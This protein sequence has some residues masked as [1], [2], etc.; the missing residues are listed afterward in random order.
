MPNE[1]TKR[2]L[3]AILSADAAGYTRLMS[4]DEVATVDRI[5]A[6]R[7][8]M[9]VRVNE[10][11]GRV[12][13]HPG[14][15]LLAEF[16]S[17]L[18]ATRCA[19][20]IQR[21][22]RNRNDDLPGTQRMPF[23]I[24]LHLG[25]VMIDHGDLYGEGINI[26]SRLEGLAEPG[27]ICISD[28]VHQVVRNKLD[29]DFEDL[30]EH[31]VKNM[32]DPV[33]VFGI[34]LGSRPSV[35]VKNEDGSSPSS[36]KPTIAVLSFDN[37]SSDPEQEYLCEGI[38]EDILNGL[39]KN[40]GLGVIA[41]TSS[42][43]FKGKN[44]DIRSIGKQ[45]NATHVLE[46]SIRKAGDRIRVTA[47]L[48]TTDTGTHLWSEQYDRKL[49]DHFEIQDDI[50]GEIL[51]ELQ[52]RLPTPEDEP[53]RTSDMEAYRAHLLGRYR[54]DRGQLIPAAAS[55]EQAISIDPDYA[56]AYAMLAY[57]HNLYVWY[58]LA[59][60]EEKLPIIRNYVTEALSRNPNQPEALLL[61]AWVGF[62]VDR[63]YENSLEKSNSL[64]RRFPNNV[65]ALFS[66]RMMRQALGRLGES[67]RHFDHT[68][69]ML[70]PLSPRAHMHRA[71]NFWQSGDYDSARVACERMVDLGME[72]P[73]LILHILFEQGDSAGM[74]DQLDRDET[75]W[76]NMSDWQPVYK[77]AASYLRGDHVETKRLL[78]PLW[79]DSIYRSYYM[80]SVMVSLEEDIELSLE[81]YSRA[82]SCSEYNA[83][84]YVQSPSHFVQLLPDYRSHP[85]YQ[86]MLKEFGLDEE[87]IAK[88]KIPPLPF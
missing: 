41:R 30:G 49:I 68:I 50:A 37:M 29:L 73:V 54:L 26:A 59:S 15:N 66:N 38:S 42:F 87:S 24:G 20:E 77:A 5:K 1:G 78:A 18:D 76:G 21:V 10:H 9:S 34:S 35:S 61:G 25:D 47:Q 39:A 69:D 7:E 63:D 88:L 56:D 6:Y 83:I 58:D 75:A 12:V 40:P 27:G 55:F 74:Q 33:H 3:A 46:G 82:L 22:L 4:D 85:K 8:L 65:N 70:D 67:F 32:P 11:H 44:L 13:D 16:P 19:V 84:Q 79:G 62:C 71:V 36:D 14:D 52:I 57:V 64:I 45:L 43:S 48:N 2:R 28:I 53:A 72:E 31:Q 51:N 60:P 81:H 86:K 80:K 17:A 23:R